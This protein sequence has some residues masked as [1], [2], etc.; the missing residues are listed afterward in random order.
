[1]V[2]MAI[3]VLVEPQP[4]RRKETATIKIFAIKVVDGVAPG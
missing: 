3:G 1:M 4:I 2:V